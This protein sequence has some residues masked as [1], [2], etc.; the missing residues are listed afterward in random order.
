MSC[1]A[2]IPFVGVSYGLIASLLFMVALAL[3]ISVVWP[4]MGM[5]ITVPKV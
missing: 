4:F 2:L 3:M 1:K 5:P